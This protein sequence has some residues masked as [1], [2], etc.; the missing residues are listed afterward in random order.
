MALACGD[1]A[2]DA[3]Q[4]INRCCTAPMRENVCSGYLQGGVMYDDYD[5]LVLGVGDIC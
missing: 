3:E 4:I 2:S 1:V 5:V